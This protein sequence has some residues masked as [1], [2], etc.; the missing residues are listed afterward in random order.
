MKM[1]KFTVLCAL[2]TAGCDQTASNNNMAGNVAM[3]AVAAVKHPTYCFF[4]DTETKGWSGSVNAKGDVVVKGKAFRSDPRYRA[5]FIDQEKTPSSLTLWLAIEQ[6][7]GYASPDNWWS[8]AET[9]PDTAGVQTVTVKCGA[10]TLAEL[11]VRRG[12]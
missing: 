10:K 8:M 11:K 6:N 2:L 3:N 7:P 4:K 12:G 1:R 5:K 9:V